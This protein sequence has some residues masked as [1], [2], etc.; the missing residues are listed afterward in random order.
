VVAYAATMTVGVGAHDALA[1]S[2]PARAYL[3]LPGS[4]RARL[5]DAVVYAADLRTDLTPRWTTHS[6]S[7]CAASASDSSVRIRCPVFGVR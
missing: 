7:S 3:G 2:W 4:S 5:P 1:A 6:P